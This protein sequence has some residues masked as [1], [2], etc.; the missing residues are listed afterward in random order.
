MIASTY[1]MLGQ[2][3]AL[4][5]QLWQIAGTIGVARTNGWDVRLPKWDYAKYF[6]LPAGMFST[7]LNAYTT[8]HDL[9]PDYL[10]DRRLWQAHES[11]IDDYLRPSPMTTG[12][13]FGIYQGALENRTAVHVRRANN[14]R[15]PDH[16]PAPPLEYFEAA[17][18]L[19]GGD[20]IVFSDDMEWCRKQSIFRDAIFSPGIPGEVDVMQLTKFA[21]MSLPEAALDL[22]AMSFCRRHIISNSSFSWWGAFLSGYKNVAYPSRWYGPALEDIDTS[23]MF[24]GLEWKKVEFDPSW[25]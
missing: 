22:N 2:Q 3:G 6:N 21:P 14:L 12:L 5:N 19:I 4:G 18:D 23:V 20:L 11:T 16:H 8:V 1:S 7:D 24:E 10:Q 9:A 13:L 17:I 15:L 25:T